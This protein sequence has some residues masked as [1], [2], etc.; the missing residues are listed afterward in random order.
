MFDF[1]GTISVGRIALGLF[2]GFVIIALVGDVKGTVEAQLNAREA[3]IRSQVVLQIG[4]TTLARF[5][6]HRADEDSLTQAL[7]AAEA[8]NGELV[9][10]LAIRVQP[11]TVYVEVQ[12]VQTDFDST[13]LGIDRTASLRDTT[14]QGIEVEVDAFAPAE[15]TL[16]LQLGYRLFL[17]E[18]RPE[19]A[20]IQTDEGVYAS[21]SWLNQTFQVEAPFYRP[22]V[23]NRKPLRF[24]AGA[25]LLSPQEW[26]PLFASYVSAEYRTS[27]NTSFEI[28]VGLS[29][30]GP[31]FGVGVQHTFASYDNLW[32]L[33]NPF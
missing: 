11:D 4:E 12:D 30:N 14:S 18:Q 23:T 1:L 16:P 3:E 31:F 20:F 15:Q 27:E 17:P 8:L 2:I 5:A 7:E 28:P 6:K 25:L 33:L 26:Q 10:A 24:N 22:P 9:A 32:D 19:I 29:T 13:S 21:V